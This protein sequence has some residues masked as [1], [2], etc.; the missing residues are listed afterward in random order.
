MEAMKM[1]KFRKTLSIVIAMVFMVMGAD[2]RADEAAGG[3]PSEATPPGS[4][5]EMIK[6]K[7][8]ANVSK[9]KNVSY[10]GKQKRNKRVKV[11]NKDG[12]VLVSGK[13]SGIR[14]DG[15]YMDG[16]FFS[17]LFAD[18][19]SSAGRELTLKDLHY[20]LRANIRIEYGTVKVVRITG[21]KR[22]TQIT[23]PEKV[24][25]MRAMKMKDEREKAKAI[26]RAQEHEQGR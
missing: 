18:I 10:T 12:V 1:A 17:T 24:K 21:L 20:D 13:I 14:E 7:N 11:P 9:L 8:A 15:I 3:L 23:D 2:A 26:K 5:E 25:K 6:L 4:V 19:V 16:E 22:Y